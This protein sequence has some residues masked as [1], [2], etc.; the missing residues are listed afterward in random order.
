[1]QTHTP[2]FFCAAFLFSST[3]A[4]QVGGEVS[5]LHQI[6]GGAS[7][8]G[9]GYRVSGGGDVDGDGTPDFIIA[10]SD[11]SSVLVYSGSTGLLLHQFDEPLS[12]TSFGSSV[13]D[14][15]DVNGD[16]F[17]DIIVG[18]FRYYSGGISNSGAAYI[19]SGATG[20]LLYMH[21]GR[22]NERLGYAVSGAGDVDADGFDD[23]IVGTEFGSFAIVF[24][25]ATGAQLFRFDGAGNFDYFGQAVAGAGDI[26]N[27]GFADLL[28][29]ASK[30]D[31][32]GGISRTGSVFVY[33][34][35]SGALLY[36]FDGLQL[37]DQLG[38]SVASAGDVDGDGF[39]DMVAGA[40]YGDSAAGLDAVGSVHVYS[41][42]TGVMLHHFAG[43]GYW[44][45]FGNSVAGAGDVDGDGFD[46]LIVGERLRSST[47]TSR[48]T[49]AYLYSGATGNLLA[50]LHGTDTEHHNGNQVFGIG[51]L[52]GDGC[53]EVILGESSANPVGMY[54]SRGMAAVYSF[55][56]FITLSS[57]SVSASAGALLGIALD[58]PSAAAFDG[59][60]VLLSISGMGPFHY[61]VDIPLSLDSWVIQSFYGNYSTPFTSGMQG[62]LDSNGDAFADIGLLPGASSRL[63]GRTFWLAAI[64]NQPGQLPEYSSVAIP[65]A[66]IQ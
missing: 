34:G 57:Y 18:A 45:H 17:S 9:L 36:R 56:S 3:L 5:T 47:G 14:A 54:T 41:G 62:F 19:Y 21:E 48:A 29:G 2:L 28:V 49:S 12:A 43:E 46:D 32:S 30:S 42:A 61:G 39:I 15:G 53:H 6:D 59:Y 1:M 13:A 66:I 23:V 11:P 26:N 58:F 31:S 10:R 24:S 4:A 22:A 37:G 27:D 51:D 7:E 38:S 8:Y 40:Y 25:G 64:A 50:R 35:V 33:S 60:K 52:D 63:I 55:S 16:G 44:D 65:I 20:A